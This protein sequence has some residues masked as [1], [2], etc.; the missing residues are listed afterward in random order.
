[1]EEPKMVPVFKYAYSFHQAIGNTANRRLLSPK[2]KNLRNFE[3]S[4]PTISFPAEPPL[5]SN[6]LL[7]VTSHAITQTLYNSSLTLS[8]ALCAALPALEYPLDALLEA[9]SVIDAADLEADAATSC[10]DRD[11][12]ADTRLA[13]A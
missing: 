1:M 7:A 11:A 9:L 8:V 2:T 3:W 4:K 5:R 6:Q 12:D 10:A 13:S